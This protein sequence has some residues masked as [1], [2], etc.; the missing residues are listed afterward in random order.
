MN[1]KTMGR[2]SAVMLALVALCAGCAGKSGDKGKFPENFSSMGDTEKMAWLMQNVEPDSVARF[3]CDASLGRIEGVKID[4]LSMAALY[5]Y[6]HY[7]E[8]DLQTFQT[9][10]DGYADNLPLADKMRLRALAASDNPDAL[11]YMLGL[12]YVN[13]IR[14]GK[15]SV[16]EVETEIEALRVACEANP[17]DSLTFKRFVTGFKVALDQDGAEGIPKEIYTKYK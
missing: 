2:V 15:K 4:T 11:G 9:A 13:D 1:R 6:E 7:K 8:E 12:E 10:F 5:A 14:M 3:I 16:G 17:A